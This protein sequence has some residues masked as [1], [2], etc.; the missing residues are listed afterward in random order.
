MTLRTTALLT[1]LLAGTLGGGVVALIGALPIT[2][3]VALGAVY[4]LLFAALVGRR[5]VTPGAGLLWGLGTALLAWV[6]GPGGAVPIMRGGSSGATVAALRAA[7]PLLIAFMLGLGAPVGL[8]VGTL[9]L[10]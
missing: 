9:N 6:L 5:A 8:A 2:L 3:L 7:F 4:G 1:G 10:M